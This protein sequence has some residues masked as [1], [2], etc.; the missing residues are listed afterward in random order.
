MTDIDTEMLG[1]S[2]HFSTVSMAME[3]E[4]LIP[5]RIG[6]M[7]H[8]TKYIVVVLAQQFYLQQCTFHLTLSSM[9]HI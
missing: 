4:N 7:I 6:N 3:T 8:D 2:G 9:H 5:R 1:T